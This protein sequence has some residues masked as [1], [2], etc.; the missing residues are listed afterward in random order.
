MGRSFA[1]IIIC[2]TLIAFDAG[3]VAA[4]V[5]GSALIMV[6][7]NRAIAKPM[8][9]IAEAAWMSLMLLL[10]KVWRLRP[11]SLISEFRAG[12]VVVARPFRAIRHGQVHRRCPAGYARPSFRLPWAST[13]RR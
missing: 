7:P 10:H 12:H 8:N 13:A 9:A 1:S 11:R 4:C 2:I 5:E 3:T 6:M